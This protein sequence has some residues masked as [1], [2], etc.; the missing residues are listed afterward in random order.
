MFGDGGTQGK[1][2]AVKRSRSRPVNPTMSWSIAVAYT[3]L[4][5]LDVIVAILGDHW[6]YLFA[7]LWLLLGGGWF[8]RSHR[9]RA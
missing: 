5:V 7:V 4:A 1:L 8:Y 2:S 3:V 6:F 9:S